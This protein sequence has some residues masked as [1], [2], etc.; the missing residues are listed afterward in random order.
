MT[1]KATR[2]GS[3]NLS[4]LGSATRK[5][6][7]VTAMRPRI[8]EVQPRM[9]RQGTHKEQSTRRISMGM[10]G[11]RTDHNKQCGDRSEVVEPRSY[12]DVVVNGNTSVMT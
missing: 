12:R 3:I 9:R 11:V 4:A 8:W 5:H 2:L 7:R 1:M 10:K 6:Q